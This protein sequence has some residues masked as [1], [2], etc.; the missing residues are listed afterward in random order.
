MV[1][2]VNILL[3]IINT[4]LR[5]FYSSIESLCDDLDYSKE[6]IDEI[7]NAKGYYYDSLANQY[8]LKEN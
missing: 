7:L 4:K 1:K 2:D 6:E 3:S 5:D 8:K